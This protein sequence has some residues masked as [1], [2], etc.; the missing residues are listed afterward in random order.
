MWFAAGELCDLGPR[1]AEPWTVAGGQERPFS[2]P[3]HS[4]T[5]KQDRRPQAQ[6]SGA[7]ELL[8]G[9]YNETWLND[10]IESSKL[11]SALP[12]HVLLGR[13]RTNRAGGVACFVSGA[14]RPERRH[15]L[16]L[17]NAEVLVLKL[18]TTPPPIIAVC[19]CPPDDAWAP[20]EAMTTLDN[21]ATTSLKNL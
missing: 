15:E 7:A 16:E 3:E 10:G 13:G 6:R 2:L 5:E 20:E 14:L 11:E 9:G 18:R 19:Y 12:T 1:G 17:A 21:I 8:R 4:D